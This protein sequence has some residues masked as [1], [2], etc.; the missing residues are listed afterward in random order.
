MEIKINLTL[1]LE[2]GSVSKILK[3]LLGLRISLYL[4]VGNYI[5]KPHSL[6]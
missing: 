6:P 5:V 1:N 2:V 3:T 4:L